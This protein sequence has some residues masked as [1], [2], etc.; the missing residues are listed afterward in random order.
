MKQMYPNYLQKA[1]LLHRANLILLLTALFILQV[2]FSFAQWTRK[3][4]ALKKRSECPSVLYKGK[5]YVFG[6]FGEHPHIEKT[7]E[8]YDPALNKWTLIAPFPTGKEVTHESV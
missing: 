2:N 3:A 7:N 5:V 4:D 6:G 1:H 8:V